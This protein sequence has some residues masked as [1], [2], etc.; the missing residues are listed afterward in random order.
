MSRAIF[1]YGSL[2]FPEVWSRVVAGQYGSSAATLGDHARFA[3]RDQIY[4]GMVPARGSQVVGVLYL[5]V[6]DEDV[7]ALD[8]FEGDDYRREAIEVVCA[9]GSSRAAH[10]YVYRL[11]DRLLDASW[12]PASFAMQRFLE[13]YCRDRLGS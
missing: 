9:D 6:D 13:T 12:E 2:M 4:P 11:A 3:V 1:T 8:R 10:T 5:D 7:E